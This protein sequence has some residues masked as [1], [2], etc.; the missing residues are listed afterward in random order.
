MDNLLTIAL[1]AHHDKR[2]RHRS[3]CITIGRDLFGD[4]TVTIRYG[5]CGNYGQAQTFGGADA[6]LMRKVIRDH[7]RR[8]LS[9]PGRIGCE[10]ALESLSVAEGFDV[11][12]WLEHDLLARF[13]GES[14]R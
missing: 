1:E 12:D 11:A 4:W 14:S 5:R 2:N 6:Q 8:R 9:A 13:Q 3:Y 10:Y 7:L